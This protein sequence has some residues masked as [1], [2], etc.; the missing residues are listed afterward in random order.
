MTQVLGYEF[1]A[2]RRILES[3][4]FTIILSEARSKK[5]LTGGEKRI[6]RQQLTEGQRVLL[7]YAVFRTELNEKGM[8]CGA[9]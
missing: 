1:D 7:T 3:E 5:G 6:V 8:G 9:D 4:G 2:A